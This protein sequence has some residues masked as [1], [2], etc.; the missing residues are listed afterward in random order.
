[1]VLNDLLRFIIDNP[2]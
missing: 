1:M 2:S